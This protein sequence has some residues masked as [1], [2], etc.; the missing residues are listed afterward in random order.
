MSKEDLK[1]YDNVEIL[2]MKNFNLIELVHG[3]CEGRLGEKCNSDALLE[4]ME[5]IKENQS[6]LIDEMD[7]SNAKLGNLLVR[8]GLL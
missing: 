4:V 2:A 5:V 1:I 3:Y 8:E 7:K 6:E